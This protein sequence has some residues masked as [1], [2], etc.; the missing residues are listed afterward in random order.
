MT[1]RDE[2]IPLELVIEGSRLPVF[3]NAAGRTG[4]VIDVRLHEGQTYIPDGG[5]ENNPIQIPKGHLR[6]AIFKAPN[7]ADFDPFLDAVRQIQI[8]QNS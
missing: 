3:D 4:C 6:V 8:E 2:A 7:H 5:S 1:E